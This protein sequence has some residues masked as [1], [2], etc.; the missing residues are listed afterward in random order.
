LSKTILS[1]G[2][3]QL[4]WLGGLGVHFKLDDTDT[5]GAFSMVEHPLEPGALA[6]P[7]THTILTKTNSLMSLQER[8]V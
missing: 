8:L 4:I 1:P 7:H 5:Q 3:G 2:D 6:R